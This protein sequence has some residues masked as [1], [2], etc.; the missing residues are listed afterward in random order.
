[1]MR[2]RRRCRGVPC[3]PP[4][5]NSDRGANAISVCRGSLQANKHTSSNHYTSS[6]LEYIQSQ[7]VDSQ[8]ILLEYQINPRTR[9]I[10]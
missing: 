9:C 1:M 3:A 2:R 4:M 7:R 5:V 8:V 10:F 6:N